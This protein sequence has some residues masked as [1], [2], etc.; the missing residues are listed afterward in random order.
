MALPPSCAAALPASSRTPRQIIRAFI[1][2]LGAAT[3]NAHRGPEIF[4]KRQCRQIPICMKAW[5][6][7]AFQKPSCVD[8]VFG[9]N[10]KDFTGVIM[11]PFLRAAVLGLICLS[12]LA[13]TSAPSFAVDYPN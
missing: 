9:S 11:S 12:S 8:D 3:T 10:D 1:A 6:R 4:P 5:L 7:R 2:D 13:G